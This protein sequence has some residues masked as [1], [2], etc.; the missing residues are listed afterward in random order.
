MKTKLYHITIYMPTDYILDSYS[1]QK[2][3]DIDKVQF[4][5]HIENHFNA[6]DK[7]HLASKYDIIQALKI[8]KQTQVVPFEVEA[9]NNK[10]IK[11]C[12]RVPFNRFKDVCLAIAIRENGTLFIKTAW[13]NSKNDKHFTLDR[14][15][16]EKK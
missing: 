3:I 13:N 10:I 9:L 2:N 5:K 15:K 14:D 4:S 12:I 6:R 8:A 16:Y 1:Y 7:K 11:Y